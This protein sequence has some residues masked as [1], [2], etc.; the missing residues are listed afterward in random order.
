MLTNHHVALLVSRPQSRVVK[1][2]LI[3]VMIIMYC[4]AI[5]HM[6]I[7]WWLVGT[8]YINNGDSAASILMSIQLTPAWTDALSYGMNQLLFLLGD[9]IMVSTSRLRV[10]RTLTRYCPLDLAVL[11]DLES[12]LENC[13]PAIY[14]LTRRPK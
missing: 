3:P 10:S 1:N 14:P 11:G 13:H 6:G 12:K 7:R 2:Q 8:H 9:G 4:A 5:V